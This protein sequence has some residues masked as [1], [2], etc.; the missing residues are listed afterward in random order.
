MKLE[1]IIPIIIFLIILI[2]VKKR[3]FFWK[4]RDGR[5]LTLKQFFKMWGKG[6]EGITPIQQTLTS[7]WSYPLI[8]GGVFTGIVIMIIR[9]EWW[10]LAI[11]SGSLPLTLMSLLSLWQKYKQQKRIHDTMNELNKGEKP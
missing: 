1:W 10:L 11:L 4:A 3:G 7:L 6:I 5:K 9:K 8:L 2:R